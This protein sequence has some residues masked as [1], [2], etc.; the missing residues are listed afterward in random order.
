MPRAHSEARDGKGSIKEMIRDL[1]WT[2]EA[3]LAAQL[4]TKK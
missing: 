4:R 3:E 1:L 2:K